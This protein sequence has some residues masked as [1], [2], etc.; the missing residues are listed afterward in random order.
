M[1]HAVENP[2]A[3][4]GI[5]RAEALS[6]EERTEIAKKAADARW[7]STL[8]RAT[9]TGDLKIGDITIPCAVLEDGRRVLW[10]Q[11][12]LR[13]IGRT[14]RAK[15]QA[16]SEDASDR[17]FQLPVFL[18]AEN[19]KPF[20][21]EDL[22]EASQPIVFRPLI[23]SGRSGRSI[24]YTADLLPLVC[25]VFQD[26]KAQ[27]A[28]NQKQDHIYERCRILLRGFSNVGIIALVDEATGFQEV[29]DRKALEA[30]LDRYLRKELAAW[31]KRFPDEFYQQMFRLKEWQWDGM[32]VKRPG[33]V[34]KYTTDL[35]Y[36]RLAPGIVDELN[37][38]NPKNERGH[39]KSRHHQWL[40]EDVGHPAL[41]QH[42]YALIGF[43]RASRSWDT[44]Y[45][46]VERAFPRKNTTMLLPLPDVEVNA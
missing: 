34:G 17:S 9:H 38:L 12:F 3:K 16:L 5:A 18:R 22:T 40:T 39:R 19:L 10:Q 23:Y 24:G 33:V 46:M 32:S 35:V 20:I 21:D 31:A 2:K 29:R 4:G 8:P 30:I 14:G 42:L 7:N 26:A 25:H 1:T 15:E 36:E 27:Q 28:L 43:M 45:R 11:G 37:K 6:P 13:A 44:F 41:A